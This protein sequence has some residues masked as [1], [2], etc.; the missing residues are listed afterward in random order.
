M[1][2]KKLDILELLP[3]P[4]HPAVLCSPS[5]VGGTGS[6]R[7]FLPLS[8]SFSVLSASSAASSCH[9]DL[10]G[11]LLVRPCALQDRNFPS[12]KGRVPFRTRRN[13]LPRPSRCVWLDRRV[14]PVTREV[15]FPIFFRNEHN[16]EK[17]R[18]E[19]EKVMSG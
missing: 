8:F 4:K 3:N 15:H 6:R 19:N 11:K 17:T 9:V 7:V 18:R 2:V 5:R 12:D 13:F 14:Q 1:A 16:E 10:L